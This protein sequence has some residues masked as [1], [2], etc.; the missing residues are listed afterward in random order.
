MPAPVAVSPHR[1]PMPSHIPPGGPL[2]TWTA[3]A[4][5]ARLSII[6]SLAY[7]F[8]VFAS[9]IS[10]FVL[11]L[12]TVFIWKT[13]YRGVGTVAGVNESQMITYAILSALLGALYSSRVQS[14]IYGKVRQGQIAVDF[15]RPLDPM[16]QWLFEDIGAS[17]AAMGMY[18]VPLLVASVLF[19]KAPL[20]VS[21]AAFGLFLVSSTLTYGILWIMS[22]LMGCMA[23]WVTDLG[24]LGVVK[25]NIVRV[26]SGSFVP[27][28]FFPLP[29]RTVSKFLPFQYTYQTSL[30]I[31]V[32]KIG[33]HEALTAIGRQAIWVLILGGVL[34]LIW[35][36]AQTKLS[37]QGG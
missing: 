22:G 11:L 13:A 5:F 32:G 31:Y 16:L 25:D 24:N 3:Y 14:N 20:P 33:P 9:T 15:I 29:V 35:R 10:N 30:G 6:T 37:I 1:P 21:A 17:I 34:A 12:T 8:E 19:V 7:Q 2:T 27:I 26:F 28:W 18:L 4:Y 23:F 36:N